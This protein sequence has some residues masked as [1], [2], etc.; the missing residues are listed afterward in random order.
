MRKPVLGVSDQV[1]Y[2]P[3]LTA[4]EDGQRLEI[5]DLGSRAIVLSMWRK[6]RRDQLH[7]YRKAD[8]RLCFRICK[9]S[10]FSRRGSNLICLAR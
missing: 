3:G 6:Q 2:K 9:K 1:R 7:G 8:L 4:T 5:S 10:V